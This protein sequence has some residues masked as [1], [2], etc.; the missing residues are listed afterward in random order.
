[1]FGA[2]STRK[3]CAGNERDAPIIVIIRTGV[4]V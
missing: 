2:Q 4:F 3:R 1:V